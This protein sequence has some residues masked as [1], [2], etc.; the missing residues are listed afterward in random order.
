MKITTPAKLTPA[1]FTGKPTDWRAR[2]I[3]IGG[4]LSGEKF[5]SVNDMR[6]ALKRD[7]FVAMCAEMMVV[8]KRQNESVENIVRTIIGCAVATLS[9]ELERIEAT[10]KN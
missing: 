8:G 5:V 9:G 1:D 7:E 6:K 4:D 2:T 3:K 10:K